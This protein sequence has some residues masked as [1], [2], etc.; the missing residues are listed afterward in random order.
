L[1]LFQTKPFD[2]SGDHDGKSRV[3]PTTVI[4]EPTDNVAHLKSEIMRQ[5]ALIQA[6]QKENEK[7]YTQLKTIQVGNLVFTSD[8]S[9][10][11]CFRQSLQ[12]TVRT[13]SSQTL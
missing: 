8:S 11:Q 13:T 5:E 2:G 6:Y 9:Y 4:A 12:L 7:L 3:P 10:G 1:N